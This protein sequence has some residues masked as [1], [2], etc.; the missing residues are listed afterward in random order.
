MA[1]IRT[2]KPE[3]FRHVGLYDA[4]KETGLPLRVAFAGLW[5]VADREGRFRWEPR[6]LKLDVLPH[7]DVDFSRVLDALGT[8]G[9]VVKYQVGDSTFGAIPSWERHQV[10]NNR[11][12]VSVIPA[13]PKN[14]HQFHSFTDASATRQPRDDDGVSD[15]L[16]PAQG[17]GEGEGNRKGKG[18]DSPSLRSVAHSKISDQTKSEPDGFDAFYRAY[19]RH[20]DRDRAAAKYKIALAI[21]GQ[22]ALLTAAQ[23]YA[24][25]V[26]FTEP[27]FIAHPATWL[28][29]KRW[30]V[31]EKSA[32]AQDPKRAFAER[33]ANLFGIEARQQ[34]RN[35]ELT[36]GAD[37]ER[38]AARL[39]QFA[40]EKKPITAAN[41]W[42]FQH[43]GEGC[44]CGDMN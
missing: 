24:K 42:F 26:Q 32:S 7:D 17:E 14:P 30:A 38:A 33:V 40:A 9:F 39:E 5:T 19:P 6:N 21:T 20:V 8:R 35:F 12:I 23:A 44:V 15:V 10:V 1:R 37:L 28:H 31:E 16:F 13:P 22:E 36:F 2:I 18:K 27:K 29:N 4:E 43:G 25:S 41:N 11:E 34:L 3:F